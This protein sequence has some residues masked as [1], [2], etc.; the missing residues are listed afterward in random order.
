MKK[1]KDIVGDGGS[2]IV[3]QV[4][5]QQARLKARLAAVRYVVAIVSGKGGVGK[6]SLT[7]NLAAALAREGAAVG[8]LDADLNGPSIA[9]ML[10]VRGMKL[11]VTEAGVEPPVTA[12]GIRVMSMDLLLPSD[13]APVTWDATS[14]VDS[15]VW[16]GNM[17]ANALREFLADTAWGSLDFLLLDL[18]PGADRLSTLAG[19]VPSLSGTLVVTIPTDVSHLVVKKSITVARATGAPILGLVENMAELFQG[20]GGEALAAE[21]GIPFFGSVPFDPRLAVAADAGVPFVTEHADTPAGRAL[22]EIAGH[23]RAALAPSRSSSP[24]H[25]TSPHRGEEKM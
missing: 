17:E 5:A 18:P 3:A 19:L 21:F 13:D 8:V 14:Q 15:H 11:R 6:S 23:L 22:L 16:R 10:G 2:N 24:P 12:Q 25:P 9:K 20:T 1:Y 4:E 7:A